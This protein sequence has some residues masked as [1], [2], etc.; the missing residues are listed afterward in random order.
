MYTGGTGETYAYEVSEQ[1]FD[2]KSLEVSE[3]YGTGV[4]SPEE[5]LSHMLE[6]ARMS[7]MGRHRRFKNMPQKRLIEL[8]N[9]VAN[10]IPK[11]MIPGLP[12]I[13]SESIAV[14]QREEISDLIRYLGMKMSDGDEEFYVY[15]HPIARIPKKEQKISRRAVLSI[16]SAA[17]LDQ[18]NRYLSWRARSSDVWVK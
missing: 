15:M 11:N 17:A 18:L 13:V 14:D 5:C 10:E 16:D 6:L 9:D 1:T 7:L 12:I 3:D 2:V 8:L 4:S